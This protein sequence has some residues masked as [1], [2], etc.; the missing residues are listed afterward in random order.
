[1]C[2]DAAVSTDPLWTVTD[3]A[4]YLQVSRWM[5]ARLVEHEGLP[6]IV[7]SGG[8][9]RRRTLRFRP[10]DLEEWLAGRRERQLEALLD[11]KRYTRRR[12]VP[13]EGGGGR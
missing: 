6:T 12:I 2:Q 13:L 7:I 4:A 5:I 9:G 11:G 3:A 8:G 10:G 1:M